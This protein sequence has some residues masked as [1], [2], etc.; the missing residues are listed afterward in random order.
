MQWLT[1]TKSS[2][3]VLE[4]SRELLLTFDQICTDTN[5]SEARRYRRMIMEHKLFCLC[6]MTDIDY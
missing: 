1:R 3:R 2:E 5:E 6:L 4:C